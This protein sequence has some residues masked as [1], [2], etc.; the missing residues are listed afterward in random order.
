MIGQ[1]KYKSWFVKASLEELSQT[2][3]IFSVEGNF[4]RDYI[5]TH[6]S[7]DILGAVQVLYP[8]ITQVDF[9]ARPLEGEAC[10]N[11]RTG[12]APAKTELS[13]DNGKIGENEC[14]QR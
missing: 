11:G 4:M 9:Q 8:T 3:A 6:F 10:Q 5:N 12:F 2:K 7:R 14:N 13:Q 1:A